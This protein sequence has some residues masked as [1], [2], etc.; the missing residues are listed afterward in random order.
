MSA[1]GTAARCSSTPEAAV[2]HPFCG[3]V[4]PLNVLVTHYGAEPGGREVRRVRDAYVDAW[5]ALAPPSELRRIFTAAYA[6]GTLCKWAGE[7]LVLGS[8]TASARRQHRHKGARWLRSFEAMLGAP[9]RLG[10]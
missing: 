6:L 8:L 10:V 3:L 2:T 5:T 7:E 9:S 1:S 4:K